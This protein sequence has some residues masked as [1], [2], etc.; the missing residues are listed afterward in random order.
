MQSST[1]NIEINGLNNTKEEYE[2]LLHLKKQKEKHTLITGENI[3]L[4]FKAFDPYWH[5]LSTV[6]CL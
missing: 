6:V 5:N 2:T 4:W 3:I 1:L